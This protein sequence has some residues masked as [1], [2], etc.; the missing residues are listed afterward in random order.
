[1]ENKY[2]KKAP[3]SLLKQKVALISAYKD[4]KCS[5]DKNKKQLFWTGTIKPTVFSKEYKVFMIYE[6]WKTPKVWVVGDELERLDDKKFPHKYDIDQEAKMVRIC[7]YRYSEFNVYK[8]L[9]NTIILWTVE[10]LYF[11]ELWLATGEW[12]G[13][14]EHPNMGEEKNDDNISEK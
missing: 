3:I 13:G 14:G 9:A 5:I 12:L 8:L 2:F 6:L 7:L 10:W 11:Y 4:S 1:M